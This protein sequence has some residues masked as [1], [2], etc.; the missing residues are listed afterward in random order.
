MRP[1]YFLTDAA[2]EDLRAI[3]QY[4]ASNGETHSYAVTFPVW[5]DA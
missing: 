1:A 2:E 3:I 4:H 5:K